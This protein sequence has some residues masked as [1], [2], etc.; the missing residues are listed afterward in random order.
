MSRSN[1]SNDELAVIMTCYE[2]RF[3]KAFFKVF[4]CSEA[5]S[6]MECKASPVF[7]CCLCTEYAKAAAEL[8]IDELR[9]EY[10]EQPVA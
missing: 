1:I 8:V 7:D 9:K 6:I 5:G 3:S 10:P 4:C 2:A